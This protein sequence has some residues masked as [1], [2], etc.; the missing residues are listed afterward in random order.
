[1]QNVSKI[2][3]AVSAKQAATLRKAVKSGAYASTS[4]VIRDALR[5]WEKEKQEIEY[6]RKAWKEGIESGPS[7]PLDMAEIKAEA[8]RRFEAAKRKRKAR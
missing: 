1:M 4:E 8:R 5:L 7:V 3:I 6:L 2:S